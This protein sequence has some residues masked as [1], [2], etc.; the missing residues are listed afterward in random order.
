[1]EQVFVFVYARGGERKVLSMND[2]KRL[3]NKL[4][5][6]GWKHTAT[7]E[8]CAYIRSVELAQIQN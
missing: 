6:D 7:L 2:S 3:H 1:M 8:A 4:L 5:T